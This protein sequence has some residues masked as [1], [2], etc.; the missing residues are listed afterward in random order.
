M[1]EQL[2]FWIANCP[3]EG[4]MFI[5]HMASY[6]FS[7]FDYNILPNKCINNF[8][9]QTDTEGYDTE[10]IETDGTGTDWSETG[11]NMDEGEPEA[12]NMEHE[13]SGFQPGFQPDF[14][15]DFNLDLFQ[16]ISARIPT[17]ISAR[18]PT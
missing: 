1:S 9:E 2:K 14:N 16:R 12:N 8:G 15:L 13:S 5:E 11:N 10:G 4:R 17:W 6:D 7:D 3:D 18:I